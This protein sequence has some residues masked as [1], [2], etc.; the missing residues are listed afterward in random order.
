MKKFFLMI[1]Y[2]WAALLTGSLL[3]LL[4]GNWHLDR[5]MFSQMSLGMFGQNFLVIL[6]VISMLIMILEMDKFFGWSWTAWMGMKCVNVGISPLHIP[7]FGLFFTLLIL[8][9]VP[10]MALI[11]EMIFREGTK[12][13]PDAIWRSLVFGLCH[14]LMGIPIGAGLAMSVAGMWFSYHYMLGGVEESALH[15]GAYNTMLFSCIFLLLL[16]QHL[17]ERWRKRT[18]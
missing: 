15:H 14:C 13:W 12:S 18:M 1:K 2:L 3:F 5:Y 6:G 11:E 8:V 17:P 16:Y 4:W 9:N 7:Y 10:Y